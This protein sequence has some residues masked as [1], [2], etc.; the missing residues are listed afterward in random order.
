MIKF[1]VTWILNGEMIVEA[2]DK[3][4]AEQMAQQKLVAAVTDSQVWPQELGAQG[5]QGAATEITLEAA[6]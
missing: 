2:T 6:E 5:I 3:E 4:T 1:T